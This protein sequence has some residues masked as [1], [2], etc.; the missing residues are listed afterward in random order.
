MPKKKLPE[1]RIARI[2]RKKKKTL[3]VAE[4]CTGGL[5][6]SRITDVPGSSDYFLGGIVA[7]SNNVKISLLGVPGATIRKYGAVSRETA[8][9][10]ARGAKKVL[11]ADMAVSVTGIAGP[12]G[13]SAR[14]P[15]GLAYT[16]FVAGKAV[17][18]RK[19]NFK[20]SRTSIKAK[21][22]QAVLEM[23]EESVKR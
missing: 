3:A 13:G 9:A 16:A 20:G 14:K 7:Y 2:L 21:F 17:K 5:V 15:V 6:S 19:L 22:T 23:V 12:T 8:I 10:M 4:S 11:K 18:V 1:K